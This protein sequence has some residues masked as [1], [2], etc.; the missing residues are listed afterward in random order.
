[1][2]SKR[3]ILF[4]VLKA[5]SPLLGEGI[6]RLN[7]EDRS[8]VINAFVRGPKDGLRCYLMML[9]QRLPERRITGPDG[10]LYMEQFLLSNSTAKDSWRLR[11]HHFVRGD[12]DRELHSHPWTG[13]SFVLLGGYREEYRVPADGDCEIDYVRVRDVKPGRFNL[14]TRDTF[15]RVDLLEKDA[16]TL[17]LSSPSDGKWGFWDRKTDAYLPYEEFFKKHGLKDETFG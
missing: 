4:N 2:P 6:Y 10:T 9:R 12:Q 11:L 14:I 7:D 8:D 16:W 17:F 3:E 13:I 5:A 15:H 1:M